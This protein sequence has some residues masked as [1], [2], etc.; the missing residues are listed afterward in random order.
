MGQILIK[1]FIISYLIIAIPYLHADDGD[2][3]S[4][5]GNMITLLRNT[6]QDIEKP[7]LALEYFVRI[8]KPNTHYFDV[9][10]KINNITQDYLD[11]ALPSWSPGIYLLYD[12][13]KNLKN[14][15][16][17]D[18]VQLT[19]L[20]LKRLDKQTFRIKTA[21]IPSVALNYR[22]YA[23]HISSV[24]SYLASDGA[25]INGASVFLYPKLHEDKSISLTIVLPPG[26]K[27][28]IATGLPKNGTSFQFQAA[29][30]HQLIDCPIMMGKLSIYRFI[31]YG[32]PIH[33]VFYNTQIS[34]SF[35]NRLITNC[36]KTCY[37]A[38]KFFNGYPF[39]EYYFMLSFGNTPGHWDALEHA[40]SCMITDPNKLKTYWQLGDKS[41]LLA[42]E[43]FHVW[44][45][46]SMHPREFD[47]IDFTRENYTQCLWIVEGM[48]KYYDN[49]MRLR[50]G[51][52]SR[53]TFRNT[54]KSFITKYELNPGRNIMTLEESSFLTWFRYNSKFDTDEDNTSINYYTKGCIIGLLLDMKIR[55]ST[56]GKKGLDDV[57]KTMY[58]NYLANPKGYTE[59]E[60]YRI[61]S[62]IAGRPLYDFFEICASGTEPLPYTEIAAACGFRIEQRKKPLIHDIGVEMYKKTIINILPGSNAEKAGLQKKDKILY[63]NR[64]YFYGNLKKVLSRFKAGSVKIF[65][66]IRKEKVYSIPV[67]IG[68]KQPVAYLFEEIKNVKKETLKIREAFYT[69]KYKN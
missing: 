2:D 27:W 15:R 18:S 43:F 64:K 58:K 40:N 63:V 3:G 60:F 42:H 51:V 30:Y 14:M 66:V 31:S 7:P 53:G 52:Y 67:V 29:D 39:K 44:N 35:K 10:L 6:N 16:A 33:I 62:D 68:L 1:T 37:E 56:K 65:T 57:M 61:C 11:F 13:A 36:K 69:G 55:S 4:S 9:S 46:K 28:E 24:H 32:K 50:S 34:R 25:I 12:F 17:Y 19:N 47:N 48:T 38:G 45:G 8:L 20:P 22:I 54:F 23:N 49:V 21:N 5:S 26:K 59:E 41:R